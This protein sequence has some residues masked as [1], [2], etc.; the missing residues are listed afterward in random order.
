MCGV[1]PPDGVRRGRYRRFPMRVIGNILWL[2]LGGFAMALGYLVAGLLVCITIIGIPFGIQSFKLAG[3]A[4]WPFGR[5]V[6]DIPGTEASGLRLI[7]NVVWVLLAGWYLALGH[8]VSGLL[9]C[10]TIIGIPFGIA[11]FKMIRVAFAPFGLEIV[12]RSVAEAR[13]ARVIV[14]V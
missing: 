5:V 10:I 8:V 12:P 3:F 9:L 11:H 14:S 2:L 1:G 13:A 4:L 7:G 6:A